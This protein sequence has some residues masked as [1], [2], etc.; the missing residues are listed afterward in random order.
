M[1]YSVIGLDEKLRSENCLANRHK[2]YT[3]LETESMFDI[4]S[5]HVNV[6]NI[7]APDLVK[8]TY[9]NGATGSF[10]TSAGLYATSRLSY[11]PPKSS[12]KIVGFPVVGIYQGTGTAAADMIYPYKGANVTMGR[13]DV[14]GG[15]ASY[16]NYN[17]TKTEWRASIY[18]TNGTSTQQIKFIT[19]WIWIDYLTGIGSI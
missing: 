7:N 2:R 4:E 15:C 1:D 16:S 6:S 12:Y 13:Y 11:K 18:D 9:G 5:S 3:S 17:G 10:T 14:Q 19:D 8:R